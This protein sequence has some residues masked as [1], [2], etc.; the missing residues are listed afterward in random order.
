MVLDH[1]NGI[2]NDN[3]LCNLRLLCPNC[4]SQTD[5]FAGKK[6]K[7]K[8]QCEK[9]ICR[10]AVKCSSCYR[11]SPKHKSRKVERPSKEELRK[12]L[13]EKPTVQI[14]ADLGVSD[15]AICKWA[16]AYQID[17]PPRGYWGFKAKMSS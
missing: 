5:S 2:D 13:W 17:K 12:L 4:N 10:S 6:N 16:K 7:K 14:A 15:S 9:E 11:T 3:R 1:I 8:C